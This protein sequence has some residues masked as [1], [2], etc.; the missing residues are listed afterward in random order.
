MGVDRH[1]RVYVVW[2]TEGT[3]EIPAVYLAFSDDRGQTFSPKQQLNVSKNTFPDHPQIAVD[4]R[5]G[6]VIW[7]EQG[8]VKRDVVMSVRPTGASGLRL[9]TS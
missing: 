4:P 2:Y 5:A 7:E 9:R 3:D 1:G 8:P 6:S